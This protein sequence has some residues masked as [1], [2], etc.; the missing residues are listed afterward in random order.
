LADKAERGPKTPKTPKMQ[1][2]QKRTLFGHVMH[3]R[4]SDGDDGG[5]E[6]DTFPMQCAAKFGW[7]KHHGNAEIIKI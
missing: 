4:R 1:Q 7:E 5:H 6:E 3:E 2:N